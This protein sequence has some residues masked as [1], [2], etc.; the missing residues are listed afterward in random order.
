M[1][2]L[3]PFLVLLLLAA[4][5][6]FFMEQTEAP[7][8]SVEAPDYTA[9][10]YAVLNGNVPEFDDTE[11][12]TSAF[13]QYSELDSLGRC[14]PAYACLGREMMPTEERG[15]IG[16]VRPS[17]WHT[18]KYDSVDG[19]YLYNRCHLIG[20]QLSGENA[21]E[22]NLITGTRYFNVEGM[23]PFENLVADYIRETD[24]HVLY[25]VTPVF[26][27]KNLLASGVQIEAKSVEDAGEGICFNVFVFNRQPGIIID[28]STGDS[29]VEELPE[30]EAKDYVLNTSSRKFH[31]PDCPSV[32]DIKAAN[33]QAYSGSRTLL[34][35]Q[36]YA[37][38]KSCK[39]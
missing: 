27:G 34:I 17:G 32:S 9:A 16:Q 30:A 22:R 7:A 39:P 5:L 25:R 4:A 26:E 35:E 3:L 31:L 37:P 24:N 36:G 15:S 1:K 18:V 6:L 2:K 13:E 23:L 29:R 14:G 28:Y 10:P 38:C 8:P 20:F 19:K 11:L 33:S 21:N 12:T